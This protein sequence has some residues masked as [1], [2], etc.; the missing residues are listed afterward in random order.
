MPKKE[1]RKKIV[2]ITSATNAVKMLSPLMEAAGFGSEMQLL[3]AKAF[4]RKLDWNCRLKLKWRSH[5]LIRFILRESLVCLQ[6]LVSQQMK[7]WGT[8]LKN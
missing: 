4:I 1:E 8:L 6:K 3:T 7:Q 2:S 5:S